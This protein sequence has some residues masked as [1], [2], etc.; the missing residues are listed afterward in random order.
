M[1]AYALMEDYDSTYKIKDRKIDCYSKSQMKKMF[2]DGNFRV[3]GETLYKN[4][5]KEIG[6]IELGGETLI[7]S[8]EDSHSRLLFRVAGYINN[9]YGEY[10]ILLRR[11]FLLLWLFLGL[12]ALTAALLLLLPKDDGVLPPD[13]E[14]IADDAG[15]VM[16]VAEDEPPDCMIIRLP[17]GSIDFEMQSEV[18]IIPN[19]DVGIKVY[20]PLDDTEHWLLERTIPVNGDGT[21]PE[22]QLDFTI[23]DAELKAG[24]YIGTIHFTMADGTEE[25][26]P[27]LILVRNTFGGSMT[28]TYSNQVTVD[29]ATGEISMKYT[30]GSDADHE[31]CVVQLILDNGGREYLISQSGKLHP[32]QSLSSMHLSDG[33]AEKLTAGV[34]HGRLRLNVYKGENELTNL[35]TDIEV[36]ITVT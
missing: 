7:I 13:S 34:Y 19:E 14:N 20:A 12:L 23:L 11:N 35:N 28:V 21:L 33:A 6:T 26:L 2:P 8:E 17:M 4:K 36:T 32:G 10:I 5:K 31:D 18:G 3:I 24:R 16:E 22:W 9:G 29:R 30:Y 25:E 15:A 27:L 1:L